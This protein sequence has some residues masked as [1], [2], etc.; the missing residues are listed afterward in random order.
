MPRKAKS[1]WEF[2]DLLHEAES[3]KV[4]TVSQLTSQVRRLLEAQFGSVWVSGEISN[5]RLQVSGHI[6]FTLKDSA[7]QLSCVLFRGET[8]ADR[9]L[10]QDGRKVNL[11]GEITVYE[12]RGQYQLRVLEAELQG[13][14]RLQEAFERLKQKLSAQ[15]LFNPAHKRPL[16]R[17]PSAIGVVTSPTGAALQDVLHV[18]ERR[19]PGLRIVLAPCRVQGEG[20]AAEIAS[21]IALLNEYNSLGRNAVR[22]EAALDLILVTR[23]GGSLE[24]L[25]A[26]N[27]E[28]VARALYSSELPVISAVGHEID[29]TIADFVADIRAA[30]PSA[31]AELIT[32]GPYAG[33]QFVAGAAVR[34]RQLVLRRIERQRNVFRHDLARLNRAHP[35]R[36]LNLWLQRLDDSESRLARCTKS[37]F[38][39]KRL[40]FVIG[41]DRLTRLK[42]S[43]ILHERAL[44]LRQ[45]G[46]RLRRGPG[47]QMS[48][49]FNRLES[50]RSRLR[51]LGPEQVLA[52]G[53]SITFDART[54]AVCRNAGTLR[55]GQRLKTRLQVGE[56]HSRVQPEG[57]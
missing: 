6:Y 1:Q 21:A 44:R 23:G 52:R 30:T 53:Y 49:L 27:E 36:R 57:E 43:T 15:G 40:R 32:E 46:D 47:E 33:C 38:R 37:S 25:W 2:G 50:L 26:F 31:A 3:R 16:P 39:D 55:P 56:V 10:L 9:Q 12:P 5:L 13:L 41:V 22:P 24:D 42:P 51:L 18:I 54:G 34:L 29:F 11:R 4:L 7:A 45:L 20:A 19:Y 48:A 17:F 14:G 28:L 8:G 35:L